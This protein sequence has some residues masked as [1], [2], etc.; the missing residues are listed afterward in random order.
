MSNAARPIDVERTHEEGEPDEERRAIQDEAAGVLTY[1][2]KRR[3]SHIHPLAAMSGADLSRP[4]PPVPWLCRELQFATG[5]PLLFTA[6]AGT[7]KTWVLTSFLVSVAAERS[8]WLDRYQLQKSGPVLHLNAD[9]AKRPLIRRYQRMAKGM[10]LRLEDLPL[11]VAN[12]DVFPDGFSLLHPD[13]EE[14]LTATV[15]KYRAVVV[16]IDALNPMLG[17]A[18][19]NKAECAH[20]LRVL[21]R[22]SDRTGV[23]FFVIHHHGKPAKEGEGGG[24]KGTQHKARGSSAIV[25]ACD[26]TF[27]IERAEF[28]GGMRIEQGKAS[29]GSHIEPFYVRLEDVGPANDDGYSE[30]I[31][32]VHVD[33]DEAKQ[34]IGETPSDT[35]ALAEAIV[36]A[37][38]ERGSL[39]RQEIAAAGIV[40]GNRS[41]KGKA[42]DQLVEAGRVVSEKEGRTTMLR[43]R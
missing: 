20:A 2:P 34:L 39:S 22:V 13:A 17:G 8:F 28:D 43:L 37:L 6:A 29:M 7:G 4:L 24:R 9:M 19:E 27:S 23:T 18:D 16:L 41:M 40:T 14:T 15:E 42:M 25:D 32:V 1:Q 38:G 36:R 33:P 5:R 30:G 3:A 12:S 31:R 10:G 11:H 35:D 26:A 21:T